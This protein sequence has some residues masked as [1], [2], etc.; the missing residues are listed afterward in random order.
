MSTWVE[1]ALAILLM[2]YLATLVQAYTTGAIDE[3]IYV[4]VM[5]PIVVYMAVCVIGLCILV[6]V[7]VLLLLVL[8]GV[9]LLFVKLQLGLQKEALDNK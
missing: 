9:L 1:I 2:A 8:E 5:L 7:G 3:C 4:A 6:M